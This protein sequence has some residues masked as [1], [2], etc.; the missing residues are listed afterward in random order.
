MRN[1]LT[2]GHSPGTRVLQK[3]THSVKKQNKNQNP[4]C[5]QLGFTAPSST[6]HFPKEEGSVL[7]ALAPGD[8]LWPS[9]QQAKSTT[10]TRGDTPSALGGITVYHHPKEVLASEHS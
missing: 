9:W 3:E 1:V 7:K 4:T 2:I 6:H 5:A 10:Q 8:A